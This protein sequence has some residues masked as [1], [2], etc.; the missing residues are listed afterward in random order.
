M[1]PSWRDPA[2]EA[3]ILD[4]ISLDEPWALVERFSELTRLSGSADEAQAVEYITSKLTTWGI[5]HAV[6]HPTCL[7]SLPGQATLR[8]LGD[9]GNAFTVKTPAFSPTTNGDEVE[10]ELVYIPGNQAAGINELFSEQRTTAGQDLRGK[11]VMT[12][13]L[14]I[15]ARGFDLAGSG[16][17]AALFIN[18]GERIHEGITTTT[19]GSPDLDSL[20]RTPP[21][22]I[23]TINRPDGQELIERLGRGTVRV[24]FSNQTDTGWREIPVVVAEI[25][26]DA[27]PDDF[28]LFHGHLDSWHVGVGDNATGDA[29]LLELARV[30]QRQRDN[31]AR[32]IRVAW[33]SG[34]SHGRYAGSAWYA[35][36]FAHDILQHCIAHVNCDSP[37]CRWAKVYEN[38]S[39]MSEAGEFTKSVIRDVT[40]VEA[41]GEGHVLRA[42]DCS[43]NN[44][45]VTTFFMLSST[46]PQDLVAEKGYY[47]VGGCGGNIAWHTEDDTLDI[48]D[49]DN[50]LRDMRVYA[51]AIL[52]TVNAPILPFDYRATV[53]EITDAVNRY[54]DAAGG[55]FD[56]EP[57]IDALDALRDA[58]DE[59]YALFD[60]VDDDPERRAAANDIQIDVARILVTLGYTRD[61]R[62]RQDPARAIPPVPL[63]ASANQLADADDAMRHVILTDLAR[64]QNEVVWE[65]VQAI[66][67]VESASMAWRDESE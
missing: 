19:W 51:T 40:G 50:L 59:L 60:T 11:I 62:F 33:W 2:T 38:V 57:T 67:A 64:G 32:S 8:T 49:R 4:D 3:A 55:A 15:A 29:T 1:N 18:P 27:N 66:A 35:Q 39:W 7:I 10:A 13:G 44:L 28:L 5:E 42:G 22:P 58:L 45:G 20:G 52:R 48:A 41:S 24:A 23:L 25:T 34:H 54:Q 21:V 53:D 46:M 12:E 6:Y 61:G 56:F 9:D 17:V 47:P 30:F 16:A 26:S 31:L 43:F 37:G 14:G 36:E 65:L 63:L